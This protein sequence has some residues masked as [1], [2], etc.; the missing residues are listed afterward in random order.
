MHTYPIKLMVPPARETSKG[1]KE[2]TGLI[3][4]ARALHA[5]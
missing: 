3:D 2:K 1:D 4:Y 5:K